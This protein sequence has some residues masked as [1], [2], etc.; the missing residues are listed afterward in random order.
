MKR[1]TSVT[2]ATPIGRLMKKI[3]RQEAKVVMKPPM[4]GP[5]TGPIRAG[6]VSHVIACTSSDLGTDLR[7]TRRPTGVIRAPAKPWTRRAAISS[8]RFCARPQPMEAAVKRPIAQV[9]TG[10]APKRSAAQPLI[11]RKTAMASR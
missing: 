6:M 7:S 2:P 4:G 3:Q 10:L 11:G 1:L 5:I 9:N 8:G